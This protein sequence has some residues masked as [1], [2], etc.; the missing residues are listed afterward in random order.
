M[1]LFGKGLLI[2]SE[3]ITVLVAVVVELV[4]RDGLNLD[5]AVLIGPRK[6]VLRRQP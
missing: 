2:A 1:I 3:H 4:E 5:E 6:H